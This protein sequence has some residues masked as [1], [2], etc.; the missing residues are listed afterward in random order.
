MASRPGVTV[1]RICPSPMMACLTIPS[2]H[3]PRHLRRGR[4]AL[5]ARYSATSIPQQ[6]RAPLR[7][8]P[9]CRTRDTHHCLTPNSL[10]RRLS[11]SVRR[12]SYL[13]DPVKTAERFVPTP[14][15]LTSLTKAKRLY[16]SGDCAQVLPD[17]QISILGR[18]DNTVKIRGFKVPLRSV[19]SVLDAVDGIAKSLILSIDDPGS[20]STSALHGLGW[21]PE[22]RW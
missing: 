22:R 20:L 13:D 14:D 5:S 17:G 7:C 8:I 12:N 18:I 16:R 3:R 4:F 9:S 19:E 6:S 1:R 21:S 10:R 15:A 2:E 11:F